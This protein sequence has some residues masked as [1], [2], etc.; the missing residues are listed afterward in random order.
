[1]D[2]FTSDDDCFAVVTWPDLGYRGPPPPDC[3]MVSRECP[4]EWPHGLVSKPSKTVRD[5][6]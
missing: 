6:G 4:T 1:V 2:G 5:F 3:S